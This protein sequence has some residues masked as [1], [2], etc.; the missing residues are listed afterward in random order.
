MAKIR[1]YKGFL[2]SVE[3]EKKMKQ[4]LQEIPDVEMALKLE[5]DFNSY[6]DAICQQYEDLEEAV[7]IQ[8]AKTRH[9]IED[10]KQQIQQNQQITE[11]WHKQFEEKFEK[12]MR[13]FKMVQN[14]QRDDISEITKAVRRSNKRYKKLT[15]S[16]VTHIDTQTKAMQEICS[17][18]TETRKFK[19]PL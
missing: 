9:D 15:S 7:Q 12:N 17:K 5:A 18:L 14:S 2:F 4:V 3:V 6:R 19:S 10:L 16:L 13:A 1:E 11:Q 8:Q